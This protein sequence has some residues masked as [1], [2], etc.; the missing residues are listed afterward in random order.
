MAPLYSTL[1]T[2]H[3]VVFW[4]ANEF[5]EEVVSSEFWSANAFSEEVVSSEFW[6]ANAFSEEV[7]TS[8]FWPA[9]AVSSTLVEL[10]QHAGHA[11]HMSS[12]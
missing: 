8:E 9:N 4:S 6:S 12:F 1:S 5:S 10:L 11:E 7:V 3:E 2:L